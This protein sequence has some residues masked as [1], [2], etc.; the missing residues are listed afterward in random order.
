MDDFPGLFF[1]EGSLYASSTRFYSAPIQIR[2]DFEDDGD[3]IGIAAN[4]PYFDYSVQVFLPEDGLDAISGK[5]QWSVFD[6]EFN[7]LD[8]G[9][10]EFRVPFSAPQYSDA[11]YLKITADAITEIDSDTGDTIVT[12]AYYR[13]GIG[14]Q[15]DAAGDT[16]ADARPYAN[17]WQGTLSGSIIDEDDVDFYSVDLTADT[18]YEFTLYGLGV[19]SAG[20]RSPVLELHDDNGLVLEGSSPSISISTIRFTPESDSN[21]FL[22]VATNHDGIQEGTYFIRSEQFDDDQ[23]AGSNITRGSVTPGQTFT[24]S[25]DFEGDVDWARLETQRFYTYQV[26]SELTFETRLVNGSG[27]EIG[28]TTF[29]PSDDILSY[30]VEFSGRTPGEFRFALLDEDEDS[31]LSLATPANERIQGAIETPGD[32]DLFESALVPFVDYEI[33]VEETVQ[34]QWSGNLVVEVLD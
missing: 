27:R 12:S 9:E 22:K 33:A 2:A 28:Q 10:E 19:E 13:V 7:E 8:S 17:N 5:Y 24:N 25:V 31:D 29:T 11:R 16:I 15:G 26:E 32:V 18:D 30:F 6:D 20:L 34:G 23:L 1:E 4:D 14:Q 21:Y 3:W